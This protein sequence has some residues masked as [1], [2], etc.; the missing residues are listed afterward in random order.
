M[1]RISLS[2]QFVVVAAVA[3]A[4]ALAFATS[5]QQ[6]QQTFA[7]GVTNNTTT[8]AQG[9]GHPQGHLQAECGMGVWRSVPASANQQRFDCYPGG[10]DLLLDSSGNTRA[11]RTGTAFDL[12]YKA[13]LA[14]DAD[15]NAVYHSG[16]VAIDC[17]QGSSAQGS[18]QPAPVA[19]SATFTLTGS[20]TGI[21][22]SNVICNYATAS[23][24]PG[25]RCPEGMPLREC[26]ELLYGV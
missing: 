16:T 22:A 3:V 24:D 20:G 8:P 26:L 1:R 18:D 17:S 11:A 6:G 2:K 10:N 14:D 25:R 21:T 19:T 13:R 23:H 12:T 9:A 5:G 15:G 7:V 4:L